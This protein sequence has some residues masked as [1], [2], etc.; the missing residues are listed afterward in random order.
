MVF[1]DLHTHS[2]SPTA[3]TFIF[4]Y[5]AASNLGFDETIQYQSVGIHP[6]SLSKLEISSALTRVKE[7]ASRRNVI[8]IG[9]CGLDT[10]SQVSLS[11][12]E[13]VLVEQLKI[14]SQL[15][16]PVIIHCVK[17]HNEL[18]RIAKREKVSIPLVIHGFDGNLNI[19]QQ[20][21]K[22]G[23]YL[24]FGKALLRPHSNAA[25]ILKD[26]PLERIFIETDDSTLPIETLY[27]TAGQIVNLEL[28]EIATIIMDNFNRVF[29]T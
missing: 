9:E 14:A 11:L 1:I 12:Q 29:R 22:N 8:A 2:V 26:W 16:K 15:G 10:L 24:S 17:A 21:W 3:Q 19:A 27:Q 23:Y 7:L 20:L 18:I 13:K 28:I 5:D 25:N 4:N 6:W